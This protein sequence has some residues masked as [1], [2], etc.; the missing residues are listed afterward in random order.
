MLEKKVS[1]SPTL[2][3]ALER[4]RAGVAALRGLEVQTPPG[5]RARVLTERA[6]PSPP[7]AAPA[8]YRWR[9]GSG[10]GGIRTD[11][12]GA[13]ALGCR[14]PDGGPGGAALEA[15]GHGV[16]AGRALEPEAAR[17][18]CRG[19]PL[20]ELDQGVRLAAGGDQV[21][22]ARWPRYQDRLLRARREADRLHDR[23]RQRDRS[24]PAAPERRAS[25]ASPST[26]PATRVAGLSPGGAPAGPASSRAPG[27]ATTSCSSLRRGRA[28]G[29]C[30]SDPV[31][32][33]GRTP[34]TRSRGRRGPHRQRSFESPGR[35]PARATSP[36][37]SSSRPT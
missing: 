17:R 28:T 21:R 23:L 24:P 31:R 4:Q 7:C 37:S 32:S 14:W 36:K 16:S 3:A 25:T 26:Q 9:P 35:C 8:G 34:P 11:R 1:V 33:G 29:R 22:P 19:C 12:S 15:P 2:R 6:T 30:P 27:S 5:L 13:V 18:G 20:P 10:R